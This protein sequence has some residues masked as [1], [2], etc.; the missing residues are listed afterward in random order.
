MGE[1][2]TSSTGQVLLQASGGKHLDLCPVKSEK[3]IMAGTVAL[4]AGGGAK[5][6]C[7]MPRSTS[8]SWD[9]GSVVGLL[10][11]SFVTTGYLRQ[12]MQFLAEWPWTVVVRNNRLLSPLS[13]SLLSCHHAVI[14]LIT[15]YFYLGALTPSSPQTFLHFR[16]D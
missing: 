14:V 7:L 6:L 9:F 13:P 2:T 4:G 10:S 15:R 11:P 5:D 12:C 1:T 3:A 16:R 8:Y